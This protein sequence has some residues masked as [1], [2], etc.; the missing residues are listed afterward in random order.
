[1]TK[2]FSLLFSTCFIV[3]IIIILM[4]RIVKYEPNYTVETLN[5]GWMVNYHDAQYIN[6]D[7]STLNAHIKEDFNKNDIITLTH[8]LKQ[9]YEEI[10][11]FTILF[12]TRYCAYEVFLDDVLIRSEYIDDFYND[13]FIG[14]GYRF[15]TLDNIIKAQRISFVL[16]ISEEDSPSNF[17]SPVVGNYDDIV[18]KLITQS[19]LP[20]FMGL[21]L[22]MFGASFFIISVVFI[23]YSKESIPQMLLSVI[24]TQIG[25]WTLCTYDMMPLLLNV[26]YVTVIEYISLYFIIPLIYLT[27]GYLHRNNISKAF[28][29]MGI[30]SGCFS[31]LFII[32]HFANVVHIN[33]FLTLY[34]LIAFISIIVLFYIYI[35]DLKSKTKTPSTLAIMTG[36]TVL[37]ISLLI[38]AI[39]ILLYRVA[40]FLNT[41]LLKALFP[42]GAAIFVITQL[43][44]YFIF[45][46]QSMARR[47]EYA[48]LTQLAYNDAL[49]G[50]ANRA[51]C[52]AALTEIDKTDKDYCI[53]SLDLN[54]LKEVND[55]AGHPEGDRLLKSFSLALKS[56]LE[57]IQ[58]AL[59]GRVGGDEF[60]V[61]IPQTSE[62]EVESIID[63]LNSKLQMMDEI[64]PEFIHSVAI[65]YAFKHETENGTSHTVYMLA[66]KRMYEKKRMQHEIQNRIRNK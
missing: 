46:T 32:L 24:N 60:L 30:G 1:M 16:Y 55:N 15:V 49:T 45:L 66:D 18:H 33:H 36:I 28:V 21:F 44:N 64:E 31:L 9:E 56:T 17:M 2:K 63:K 51:R 59:C 43:F 58:D 65:G 62:E 26:K 39:Y 8:S 50:L 52:D 53:I 34:D 20:F 37:C 48:S 4:S 40:D 25:I 6:V 14:C 11:N 10:P 23:P 35:S 3:F 38:Y 7:L 27:V 13:K 54:G 22:I 41:P 47:K 61:L 5:S 42:I 19:A 12:K 29:I 57:N